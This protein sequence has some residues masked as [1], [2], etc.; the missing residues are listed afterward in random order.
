MDVNPDQMVVAGKLSAQSVLV[1]IFDWMN[2]VTLR[3]ASTV[4]TLDEFMSATLRHKLPRAVNLR[5]HPP[6]SHNHAIPGVDH[7]NNAFRRTHGLGD[8]F[9]VMYAGNHAIQHPLDTLLDA[10]HELED[11]PR[12]VFV[13]VGGGA[14]KAG[15]EHRIGQGARNIVSLPYQPLQTLDE[16]L[17]A[18]DVH[19]VS[20]GEGMV[21]IVHPCKIY[22]ALVAA[23]P[24]LAFGPEQSHIGRLVPGSGLGWR[25]D[26]GDVKATVAVLRAAVDMPPHDLRE[27]GA[28]AARLAADQFRAQQLI[29]DFCDIACDSSG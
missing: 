21:G 28:R 4:V 22:G 3:R 15:V 14:G 12:V 2:R 7:Q 1:R 9:V 25:V 10:A 26:H 24:V 17:A 23:R 5:V 27:M 6:W 11:D 29:S 13:F 16:M 19:V 8:R 20:M 18:A